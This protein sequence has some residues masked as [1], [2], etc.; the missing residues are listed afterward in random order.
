MISILVFPSPISPH[1]LGP[2]F[3]LPFGTSPFMFHRYF[4]LHVSNFMSGHINVET[5][6]LFCLFFLVNRWSTNL[7]LPIGGPDTP[8]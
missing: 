1:I 6:K 5:K 7:F 3:Y 8:S 2:Y 4:G